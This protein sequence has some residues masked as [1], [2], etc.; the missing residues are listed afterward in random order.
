MCASDAVTGRPRT[1]SVHPS[2]WQEVEGATDRRKMS[3]PLEAAVIDNRRRTTYAGAALLLLIVAALYTAINVRA[4]M[5]AHVIVGVL[6]IGPLAL[7]LGSVAY[8]FVAYYRGAPAFVQ[9]GPPPAA[10][11]ILAPALVVSTLTLVASGVG[12]LVFGVHRA[13]FLLFVHVFSFMVW[14]P[15]LA[16]HASAHV[17]QVAARV[18]VDVRRSGGFPERRSV[19]LLALSLGVGA[20][21]AWAAESGAGPLAAWARSNAIGPIPLVVGL[22]IAA[23]ALAIGK[24]SRWS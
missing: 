4:L 5:W 6:L 12:L 2:Q 18:L 15:L 14:L 8:R 22:L 3:P 19:V 24:P 11:R 20:G 7:K 16:L 23:L 21:A 10:L 13:H 1:G 9:A 17:R